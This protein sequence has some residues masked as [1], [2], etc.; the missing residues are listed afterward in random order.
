M[1]SHSEFGGKAQDAYH[2]FLAA[3]GRALQHEYG[4]STFASHK[5]NT[6]QFRLEHL[7]LGVDALLDLTTL[8]REFVPRGYVPRPEGL[9]YSPQE[10]ETVADIEKFARK[11]LRLVIGL[12]RR[13]GVDPNSG[14]VVEK[15]GRHRR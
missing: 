7:Q 6:L 12:C 2:Y 5:D 1:S 14:R 3:G 10:V 13:V 11:G 15:R 8:A 9:D 4:E